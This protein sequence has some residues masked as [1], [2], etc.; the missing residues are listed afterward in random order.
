MQGT[1]LGGTVG[2]EPQDQL[3][4]IVTAF[5]GFYGLREMASREATPSLDLERVDRRI[6]ESLAGE[7]GLDLEEVSV[8]LYRG[9]VTS[10]EEEGNELLAWAFAHAARW[11]AR[12]AQAGHLEG[13]AWSL[14]AR[15]EEELG[16]ATE[17]LAACR[18]AYELVGPFGKPGD[19]AVCASA[20]ARALQYQEEFEE[21]EQRFEEAAGYYRRAGIAEDS[22]RCLA[23]AGVIKNLRGKCPEAIQFLLEARE[24]YEACGLLGN[25]GACES[26]LGATFSNMDNLPEA[27][28]WL[29]R[30]RRSFTDYGD[31]VHAA[32]CSALLGRVALRLGAAPEGQRALALAAEELSQCGQL[33]EAGEA[34]L[35]LGS[36]LYIARNNESARAPLARARSIFSGIENRLKTADCDLNLAMILQDTK[37]LVEAERLYRSVL[38]TYRDAND[39]KRQATALLNLGTVLADGRK[40][41]GALQ[42]YKQAR[43][44]FGDN[45]PV[46]QAR[47]DFNSARALYELGRVPEAR[48]LMDECRF[49]FEQRSAQRE[50]AGCWLDLSKFAVDRGDLPEAEE[51]LGR[52]KE[53]FVAVG[54]KTAESSCLQNL[55]FLARSR[56]DLSQ[57]RSYL[58]AARDLLRQIGDPVELAHCD[59][60]LAMLRWDEGDHEQAAEL[61][62]QARSV[63][64]AN[65]EE[66]RAAE[67]DINLNYI[68]VHRG[69][70]DLAAALLLRAREVFVK[71]SIALGGAQC[72]RTLGAI[73]RRQGHL[74]LAA[75]LFQN[76]RETFLAAGIPN[77][78]AGCDH[79]LGMVRHRQ[80]RLEEAVALF[81][82]ALTVFG[83]KPLIDWDST[84]KCYILRGIVRMEQWDKGTERGTTEALR[85]ALADFEA[86][87][88]ILEFTRSSIQSSLTR[89]DFMDQKHG[90]YAYAIDAALRLART[91]PT[92]SPEAREYTAR[93]YQFLLNWKARTLAES[94]GTDPLAARLARLPDDKRA[95]LESAER[96]A[97]H[98]RREL[99]VRHD[100]PSHF[101]FDGPASPMGGTEEGI[102]ARL[103]QA[104][105]EVRRALAELEGDSAAT[106][107]S[108]AMTLQQIQ[109]ML[110]PED[111]VLDYFICPA[112]VRVS[113]MENHGGAEVFAISADGLEAFPLADNTLDT[114]EET[115]QQIN[116]YPAGSEAA[117]RALQYR[118]LDLSFVLIPPVLE[119]RITQARHLYIVPQGELTRTPLMQLLFPGDGASLMPLMNGGRSLSM[120]P[121]AGMLAAIRNRA[122]STPK[123]VPSLALLAIGADLD[124][125][126]AIPA[127]DAEARWAAASY[128]SDPVEVRT[129]TT[130]AMA[131]SELLQRQDT[132]EVLEVGAHGVLDRTRGEVSMLLWES[133][134]E[135]PCLLGAR[136]IEARMQVQ[137]NLVVLLVCFS[138][139]SEGGN[140]W[141]GLARAVFT[142]TRAQAMIVCLWT[143]DDLACAWFARRF[144]AIW[145]STGCEV[146]QAFAEAIADLRRVKWE[147]LV[148]AEASPANTRK[149]LDGATR[150]FDQFQTYGAF[151]LIGDP[152]LRPFDWSPR[153]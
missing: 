103:T 20:L 108:D 116:Q 131:V 107:S 44:L 4:L 18:K 96:R 143:V 90:P 41:E 62:S 57:C 145:R 26:E 122:V 2:M 142:A 124:Q 130:S 99:L 59:A 147:T 127:V 98:L 105:D 36:A 110:Q 51:L 119:Q 42:T 84:W 1:R 8:S 34:Y 38:E 76:A 68:E 31:A 5:M 151:E 72:E 81:N 9:A 137:A 104:D 82:E 78:V 63:L 153:A 25:V 115:V 118:M 74:D 134:P 39:A 83:Q 3:E 46:D 109:Q 58:A 53:L 6:R 128:G 144:H 66:I 87:L 148:E 67:C 43:E 21:A 92:G 7:T 100:G 97:D 139:H 61:L 19:V 69:N 91:F 45:A 125:D 55:S 24:T 10:L 16:W 89:I 32:R 71:K 70:L 140:E 94:L 111:I 11:C 149:P 136:A 129:T 13:A 12:E 56:G 50:L 23:E 75:S 114:I 48:E 88:Q 95:Q 106:S 133:H 29:D 65:G 30:A 17:R 54:D 141:L 152:T 35:D 60:K 138:G 80:G 85:N 28:L 40:Y 77:E 33:V 135:G 15:A 73:R 113:W 37:D 126:R 120:L 64:A 47:C 102:R 121:T 52:A 123:S 22:A 79:Q 14:V 101:L 132:V 93:A 27:T 86:T 112:N 49:V 146:S 117:S 150:V